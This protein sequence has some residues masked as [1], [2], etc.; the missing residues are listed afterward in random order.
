M[1]SNVVI[2][3]QIERLESELRDTER[4]MN[5]PSTGNV[6]KIH[7][8]SLTKNIESLLEKLNEQ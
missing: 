4:E 1:E 2:L 7:I 5:R 6:A 3:E 8:D